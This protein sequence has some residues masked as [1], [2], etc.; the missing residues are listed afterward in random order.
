MPETSAGEILSV[1]VDWIT[2][3]GDTATRLPSMVQVASD[4]VTWRMQTGHQRKG[5]GMAG[6]SGVQ[7]VGVQ[8]GIRGDESIVRLSSD[9]AHSHWKTIAE[10]GTNVTRLDLECTTRTNETPEQRI[11][12]CYKAALRFSE[13]KKKAPAVTIVRCSTGGCTVYLGKRQSNLFGRIYD[14]YAECKDDRYRGAVRFEL[15]IKGCRARL[16]TASLL[17]QRW[18]SD[19]IASRLTWF[20]R[21]RGIRFDVGLDPMCLPT[22]PPIAADHRRQLAW[23]ASQCRPTVQRLVQAGMAREVCDALG[24]AQIAEADAHASK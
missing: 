5:W 6:F 10:L 7:S 2:V 8:Y 12:R 24:L 20:F 16:A 11:M 21:N 23:L 4:L 22:A 13:G 3:V 9:L 18:P 19:S 14:K 15:E 1:G 17:S